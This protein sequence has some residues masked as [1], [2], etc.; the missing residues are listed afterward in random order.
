MI[1]RRTSETGGTSSLTVHT[2]C[3]DPANHRC[4][5]SILAAVTWKKKEK[6]ERCI[7]S[8][9]DEARKSNRSGS[10]CTTWLHRAN[11]FHWDRQ[12]RSYSLTDKRI[13]QDT[14]CTEQRCPTNTSLEKKTCSPSKYETTFTKSSKPEGQGRRTANARCGHENPFGQEVQAVAPDNAY[15]PA[16]QLLPPPET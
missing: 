16:V 13:R 2:E 1:S 4:N 9:T 14:T 15:L 3:A 6:T 7:T 5:G 10:S 8:K 11:T 12:Q